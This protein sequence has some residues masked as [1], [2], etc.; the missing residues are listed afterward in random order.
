MRQTFFAP[1][2]IGAWLVVSAATAADDPLRYYKAGLSADVW[3]LAESTFAPWST[4]FKDQP[5]DP[6]RL[7]PGE[8]TIIF[9]ADRIEAP[10]P[11][12]CAKPKYEFKMITA[13][14]LFGG[15]LEKP[16]QEDLGFDAKDIV[17]LDT[18]C[19]M[20]VL[21]TSDRQIRTRHR[22]ELSQDPARMDRLSGRALR[23]SAN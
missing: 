14:K 13:D 3:G 22:R 16:A 7:V 4:D 17:V 8:S 6:T 20:D 23:A 5:R 15:R 18:G 10:D 11:F 2:V 12:G 19:G 9:R 1:A 21:Q